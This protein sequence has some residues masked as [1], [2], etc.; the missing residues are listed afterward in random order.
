MGPTVH[1]PTFP[2]D[3]AAAYP[4]MEADVRRMTEHFLSVYTPGTATEVVVSATLRWELFKRDYR[5]DPPVND[6][7]TA[8][9]AAATLEV[10][11]VFDGEPNTTATKHIPPDE[12]KDPVSQRILS[13]QLWASVLAG[14]QKI[15]GGQTAKMLAAIEDEGGDEQ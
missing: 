8:W 12:L 10:K 15:I 14:R 6:L 3:V 1:Y 7:H 11:E 5:L 13:F 9:I 4:S 2:P